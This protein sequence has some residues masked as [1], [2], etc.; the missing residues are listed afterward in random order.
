MYLG[1]IAQFSEFYIT[2]MNLEEILS[3]EQ[4]VQLNRTLWGV[5]PVQGDSLPLVIALIHPSD[6][7]IEM[8]EPPARIG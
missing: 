1:Q 6:R 3:E 5:Y 7:N 4:Y 8:P 2:N